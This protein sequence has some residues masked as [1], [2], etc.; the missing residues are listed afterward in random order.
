MKTKTMLKT[1]IETAKDFV[2][3]NSQRRRVSELETT[4]VQDSLSV[5]GIK[6][7]APELYEIIDAYNHSMMQLS[8]LNREFYSSVQTTP[9]AREIDEKRKAVIGAYKTLAQNYKSFPVAESLHES[10]SAPSVVP[11]NDGISAY[12]VYRTLFNRL[13]DRIEEVRPECECNVGL[14]KEGLLRKIELNE[15]YKNPQIKE[16]IKIRKRG[17]YN[18]TLMGS[19][20]VSGFIINHGTIED[21]LLSNKVFDRIFFLKKSYINENLKKAGNI[22]GSLHIDKNS[23][24]YDNSLYLI[25]KF[26]EGH[27]PKTEKELRKEMN[28]LIYEKVFDSSPPDNGELLSFLKRIHRLKGNDY[29]LNRISKEQLEYPLSDEVFEIYC[30]AEDSDLFKPKGNKLEFLVLGKV[31]PIL[32]GKILGGLNLPICWWE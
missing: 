25:G 29:G 21:F 20:S 9:S 5:L 17:F 16:L 3:E 1:A 4:K 8:P 6:S 15:I 19:K 27:F 30:A 32:N 10:S 13:H 18:Q 28:G 26:K 12:D 24:R 23:E 2:S 7:S 11:N 14:T 22:F 31:D